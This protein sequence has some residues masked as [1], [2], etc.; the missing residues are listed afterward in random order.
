[1]YK[2]ERILP[3]SQIIYSTNIPAKAQVAPIY[4]PNYLK[5]DYSRSELVGHTFYNNNNNIHKNQED[6]TISSKFINIKNFH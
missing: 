1:M 3:N 2:C 6:K 5:G 4:S